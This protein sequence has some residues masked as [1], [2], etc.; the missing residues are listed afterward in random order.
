MDKP[1][2]VSNLPISQEIARDYEVIRLLGK[3][4]MG[5]VYLAEQLRVGRRRVALKVLNRAC[6]DSPDLVR[7]FENEAASAGRIQHPNVV[8]VFDSRITE[9]GQLY[10]AM[11]Y[12]EGKDLREIIEARGVLPLD[13]VIEIT[14][15][16]AAGLAAAHKLGIVHR[17]IKPD[18]IMMARRE[19]GGLIVKILDFGIARL[20][21]RSGDGSQTRTGVVMGTPFYM[22]PEQALGHTGEKIDSRSDIYSLGM[23]VYQMLTGRRCFESDS[24]MQIIYKHINEI[25]TPPSKIRPELA[26][27]GEIERVVLKSLEKLP[28]NRQATATQFAEELESA[29]KQTLL[30][31]SQET[32][33]ADYSGTVPAREYVY[34]SG[35]PTAAGPGSDLAHPAFSQSTGAVSPTTAPPVFNEP[36]QTQPQSAATSWQ[37]TTDTTTVRMPRR[38]WT[39]RNSIIAAV[40][41]LLLVAGAVV[42]VLNLGPVKERFTKARPVGPIRTLSFTV[43]RLNPAGEVV[44]ANRASARYFAEDLGN[45]LGLQMMEIPEGTFMMGTPEAERDLHPDEVPQHEVTVRNFDMS[46]DEI[47]IA[48]WQAVA[49]LPKVNRDLNPA[50]SSFPEDPRMPVENVSWFDAQE[51]CARLSAL[52]G[53]KYRLPTEAEWEYA[54]RAGTTTPFYFGPTITSN[55]V[56]YDAHYPYG[57]APRG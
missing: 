21:E 50:P 39:K 28:Q 37:G 2:D 14:K 35:T 48:E 26:Q 34:G 17:D 7:R 46:R 47:T 27:Y 22:S 51:F 49:K 15:Q 57:S 45:G 43:S 53:R 16:I 12:V 42:V 30:E 20:L 29:Y 10:V 1:Q 18:N 33:R 41:L 55:V 25:P 56:D 31:S 3:G 6:S 9:D 19:D 40:L 44:E 23:V 36:P 4:G 5:E 38:F 8:M 52:T 24:W 32:I 11:E 13:E 54:C